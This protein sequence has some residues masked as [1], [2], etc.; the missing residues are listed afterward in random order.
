AT[1]NDETLPVLKAK[2]IAGSANNQLK[3]DKHG[4]ILHEK[5]IVYAPDYV[6]NSGGVINVADELNGYNQDRALKKVDE[7]Y[8][9]LLNVY[10]ISRKEN[11]PT[12][13][14]AK[15]MA[16]ERINSMKKS[17]GQFLLN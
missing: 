4:E 16:E 8:N 12:A 10:E 17:Q 11:I 9:I 14:T 13:I 7:I 2:V 3:T 5:G 15:R 1:I 6:I